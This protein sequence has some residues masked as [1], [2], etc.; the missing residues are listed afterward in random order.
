MPI[1]HT[2]IGGYEMLDCNEWDIDDI[3]YIHDSGVPL[4]ITGIIHDSERVFLT[5]F[6]DDD[7]EFECKFGEVTD[8][9][10]RQE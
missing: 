3:V 4:K 1:G 8:Y 7:V 9:F 6:D 10:R 5:G 2:N